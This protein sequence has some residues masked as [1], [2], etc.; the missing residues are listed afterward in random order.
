MPNYVVVLPTSP[1]EVGVGFTVAD[2]PL[3]VTVVPPFASAVGTIRLEA[4]LRAT[5]GGYAPI[6][7]PIGRDAYFGADRDILASLF[8]DPVAL[9]ELHLQLLLALERECGIILEE[10]QY[11][12]EGYRPHVTAAN[13]GRTREGEELQFSQVALVE[14]SPLRLTDIHSVVATVDL[15][16]SALVASGEEDE[17]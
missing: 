2:W 16:A 15:D 1:F 5:A 12:R 13:T 10:P 3:H 4:V 9:V 14:M 11:S 6:N 8:A 7:V 17:V